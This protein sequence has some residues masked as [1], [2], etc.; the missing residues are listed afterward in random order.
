MKVLP[1]FRK[2]KNLNIIP[3]GL[4]FFHMETIDSEINSLSQMTP[5]ESSEYE[6]FIDMLNE[7]SFL[8]HI[9]D[10]DKNDFFLI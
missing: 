2:I 8:N 9:S 4:F 10:D 1:P 3:T 5:E 7:K 6:S